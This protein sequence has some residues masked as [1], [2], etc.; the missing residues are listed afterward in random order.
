MS[1][2]RPI[3]VKRG[4]GD[5]ITVSYEVQREDTESWD[6][7]SVSTSDQ[8]RTSF[9]QAFDELLETA[10]DICELPEEYGEAMKVTGVSF[11]YGGEMEVMGAV[12]TCQKE[13]ATA[14]CPLV[15]N[16]PHL[17]S[18]DYSEEG[19]CPTLDPVSITRLEN[20]GTEA[21]A[22]AQGKRAQMELELDKKTE[23]KN[24]TEAMDE[25]KG[26]AIKLIAETRRPSTSM[27]QRRLNIGYT[28][29]ARIM[30]LLEEDGIIGPPRGSNPREILID[31][32]TGSAA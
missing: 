10:L 14:N 1:D 17:P 11:S 4:K 12:I 3:K 9:L 7:F 20:L 32:N 6:Q 21:I 26:E 8:P 19:N 16:T 27:L 13:L 5:R 29:A 24:E 22:Y 15:V 30:D 28:R 25:L 23:A 2:T 31:L 18:E